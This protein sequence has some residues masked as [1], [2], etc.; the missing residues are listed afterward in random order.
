MS[1]IRDI[2]PARPGEIL[3]L[4]FLEPIGLTE[5]RLAKEIH[6]PQRRINEIIHL[7]HHPSPARNLNR[8]GSETSA[9][10]RHLRRTVGE[11]AISLQPAEGTGPSAGRTR[12]D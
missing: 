8:Y 10:L 7:R 5:Y 1:R 6:V 3:K 9:L 12:I 4:Y 11:P 2:P